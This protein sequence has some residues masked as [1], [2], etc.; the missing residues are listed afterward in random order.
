MPSEESPEA[1][2]DRLKKQLQDSI[3]RDYPNPRR[4][5]CPNG[6]IIREL[7]GRGLEQAIEDDPNWHHI[8][9]CSECYRSFLSLN[10]ESR[11]RTRVLTIGLWWGVA[12]TA[13]LIA[14]FVAIKQGYL[15]PK[16]P[17]NAELAYVKRTVD[18]PSVTRSGDGVEQKP[19]VLER[20]LLELTV[21]L[22]IGSKAG[23]YIVQLT[24][25]GRVVVSSQ[26]TAA[27]R[28]GVTTLVVRLDLSG[29]VSGNYAIG[30]R[31]LPFDWNYYPVEI[32]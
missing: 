9:H 21:A 4:E 20:A 5:G 1:K 22:P 15:Y 23:D 32:R 29:V 16:R 25:D 27:I 18:I 31:R 24:R 28:D 2:F 7:A 8:T 17:Q 14:G 26:A 30:V 6:R 19:I 11:D 12:A 3:L 13:V 10:R